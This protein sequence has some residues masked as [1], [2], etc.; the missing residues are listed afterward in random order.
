MHELSSFQFVLAMHRFGCRMRRGSLREAVD[1]TV[2]VTCPGWDLRDHYQQSNIVELLQES[3]RI[4]PVRCTL[5][6]CQLTQCPSDFNLAGNVSTLRRIR[7]AL[8]SLESH[9]SSSLCWPKTNIHSEDV[10]DDCVL[11]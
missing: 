4:P 2:C 10:A 1:W 7:G 3:R 11:W 6:R 9:H 8:P 5:V